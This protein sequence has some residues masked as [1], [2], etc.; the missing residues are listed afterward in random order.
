[1]KLRNRL[2]ITFAGASTALLFAMRL[3]TIE[4]FRRV[5]EYELDEGLRARARQEGNEIA[6]VGRKALESEYEAQGEAQGE[7]NAL[8]QIV[9]YGALYRADGALVADTPSFAHAPS[10]REMK[11]AV[12]PVVKPPTAPFDF[13]FRD[14]V[15][16][17]VLVEVKSASPAEPQY[18]LL[19]ASRR[20][21]DADARQLLAVGWWVALAWLPVTLAVGWW[22]GRRMTQGVEALGAAARR[23]TAGELRMPVESPAVTRDDEVAVLGQALRDMVSR[24]EALIQTERR[25]ASHA[26]HELRS[27]LTAL[28]GELELA[29]RRKRS[30]EEY[31]ATVAGALD[32]TNRLID[33][34]EDLLVVARLGSEAPEQVEESD[35]LALV[36]DA[37][38]AS[39]VASRDVAVTVDHDD[40]SVAA[41]VRVAASGFVRMLRNLI[42][43]AVVHGATKDVRVKLSRD[44]ASLRISVED[45]GPGISVEDRDRVFDHF[46]RGADARQDSGAGLGLGIARE[47]ARRHGGDVVLESAAKPTR[48]VVTLPIASA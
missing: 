24:L 12:D 28:R 23:V 48:F 41:R 42:D 17:G 47:I 14:K 19:A 30:A 32:D 20:D 10:L 31:E 39:L 36:D 37:V 7:V 43:N 1:M 33:L 13:R 8:E 22:F 18:L 25:F 15:L 5:Q 21:M 44:G 3:A 9:T 16:R 34:A 29:L 11:I 2:M 6:L 4:S 27:P 45:D 40:A 38:A 46:H 26:A 35:A